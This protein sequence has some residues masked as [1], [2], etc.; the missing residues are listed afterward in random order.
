M[1]TLNKISYKKLFFSVLSLALLFFT[2]KLMLSGAGLSTKGRGVLLL[3]S[4]ILILNSS[5]K[6]FWFLVFPAALLHAFYA[7]IGLIFGPVSYQYAASIFSTDL[8]ETS[9][10]FSQ[11]P[12]KS[13]FYPFFIIAGILLF[14]YLTTKFEIDFY[15]NKTLLCIIIVFAMLQQTPLQ[16]IRSVIDSSSKVKNELDELNKLT[17]ENA[18]PDSILVNSEY[19]NYVLVIGESARRDYHHA[20]GYAI[21]NTPFMDN[22]NGVLVNGLTAGGPN[23][24]SSLRL[25]LTAPNTAQWEPN[26]SLNLVDLAKSANIKTY[27]VSN[28]PYIGEFDTPISAIAKRS[29]YKFFTKYTGR[30]QK[31]TSDFNLPAEISEIV[32]QNPNEKKLIIVHLYG[33]HPKACERVVDY[34]E[35]ISIQN[36]RFKQLNCYVSS[37][38]KTDDILR[39]IYDLLENEYVKNDATYSMIYFSDHGLSHEIHDSNSEIQLVSSIGNKE[40]YEIPLFM[41]ASNSQNR[42]ECSAFK[43]G[44]NFVNG[45]ANWMGIQNERLSPAYSLFD[46]V[47][48]P[49]NY[50]LPSRLT[51][52]NRTPDPA[53]DIRDK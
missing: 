12:I 9:E 36:S 10:F 37:I 26:Y 22:T 2:A 28:Q 7:P 31:Q 29:D 49:D 42:Q 27:W 16:F 33:S 46:C 41:T 11:I 50:G 53:I 4:L 20:Y 23:T 5:K 39:S 32:S 38:H 14:R 17:L 1:F 3:V 35:I 40:D 52:A 25:M 30:D 44:L 43:S 19:D 8:V 6:A 45:L 15:K 51:S 21:S 47:D 24:I 18:W 13:Y 48:D 34:K